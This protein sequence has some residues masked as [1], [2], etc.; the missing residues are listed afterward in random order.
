MLYLFYQVFIWIIFHVLYVLCIIEFI[1][2]KGNVSHSKKPK[3][4][5]SIGDKTCYNNYFSDKPAIE[6][7]DWIEN[8]PQ[9]IQYPN[10]L[11]TNHVKEHVFL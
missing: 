9:L 6:L 3:V 1:V 10:V 7:R 11:D 8:H 2:L 4:D 5:S